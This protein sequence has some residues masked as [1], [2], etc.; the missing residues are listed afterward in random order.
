MS[1]FFKSNIFSTLYFKSNQIKLF[2][3]LT[4]FKFFQIKYL[5][6]QNIQIKSNL[7][8]KINNQIKSNSVQSQIWDVAI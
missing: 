2:E 8:H 4:K 6:K 7:A 3:N 5:F 1:V